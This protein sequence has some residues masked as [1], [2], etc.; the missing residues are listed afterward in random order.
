MNQPVMEAT[1]LHKVVETGVTTVRPVLYVVTINEM[2]M[3]TPRE[4]A[5]LVSRL[6]STSHR[7]RNNP[8]FASNRQ[9]FAL[10][11]L[12]DPGDGAV[13][14]DSPRRYRGNVGSILDMGWFFI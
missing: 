6:Q 1:Q 9:W 12:N 10:F 13:T 14:T 3:S 11:I 7:G 5:I 8:R 2:L 4:A